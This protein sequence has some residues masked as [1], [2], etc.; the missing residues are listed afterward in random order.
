VETR[1]NGKYNAWN[2]NNNK[3]GIMEYYGNKIS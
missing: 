2:N 1:G 3:T